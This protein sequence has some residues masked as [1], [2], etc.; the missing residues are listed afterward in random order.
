MAVAGASNP[1][2]TTV[3]DAS[4]HSPELHLVTNP[5]EEVEALADNIRTMLDAGYKLQEQA[6][7][8]TGQDRLSRIGKALERMG[9]PVLHLGN[10]FERD[11]IR[12]LLS[13]C[14]LISD[15]R[16]MGLLRV[17][18]M[19]GYELSLTDTS[20]LLDHLRESD[21]EPLEWSQQSFDAPNVSSAGKATLKSCLLYTSPSPRDRG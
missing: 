5:E 20:A 13:L 16:A 17:G 11:E 15:S 14:S 21:C 12:N 6:I 1:T 7:L 2:F 9:I 3:K 19:A 18:A 10:L 4:S 8:C